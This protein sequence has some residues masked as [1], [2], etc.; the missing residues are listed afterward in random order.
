MTSA[1]VKTLDAVNKAVHMSGA[2]LFAYSLYYYYTYVNVPA[3]LNPLDEAI[4]GKFKYLTFCNLASST[5]EKPHTQ[6]V[7]PPTNNAV[8]GRWY[9]SGK[10]PNAE[11]SYV[12]TNVSPYDLKTDIKKKYFEFLKANF[13]R[14]NFQ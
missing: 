11:A 10:W 4:G 6:L 9:D 12:G 13:T 1:A 3:H 8:Q 7:F 2:A 14:Y 5:R